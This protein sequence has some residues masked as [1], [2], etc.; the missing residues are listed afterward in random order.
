MMLMAVL[1]APPALDAQQRTDAPRTRRDSAAQALRGVLITAPRRAGT[2]TTAPR[3]VANMLTTGTKSEVIAISGT[4]T[5]VAE[6]VGRQLFAEVP[7]LFVYDMDGS[8]NQLN[9]SARGLDA[10]RS[11]EFSVRQNG[12]VTNSDVYGY[13]ASH[14]SAPMEAIERVELVRGTAALQYGSQFGGMLN[15][16]VKTP[17]TTRAATFDSRSS[18]GSFGLLSTWNSVGGKVGR[19]AY[20]AYASAR[21]SDGYRTNG[22]S[23]SDAEYASASLPLSSNLALRAD[24]ARSRYLYQQPGPLTD[25]MFAVDPRQSTR[26]RNWYSPDIIVPSVSLSWTPTS[27]TR[28]TLLVSGVFGSRSSVAIGGF[29]VQADTAVGGQFAVRQVDVD[30]YDSRTV[31]LRGMHDRT[32]FSR[33]STLSAGVILSDNDLWRRQRGAGSRGTDYSL[34]LQPNATFQRNLHYL[35]ENIAAFSELEVRVTPLWTIIPGARVERGTT[36]LRGSLAYYDPADTP[37]NVSHNFPLFGIRSSY[38][39]VSGGEWYGGGSQAYR[40]MILKDVLPETATERTDRTLKDA[41]GWTIET[42]FRRSF[43]GGFSY[44]V[45]GFAMRYANR[46]GLLTLTDSLGAAYT[47]KTNVGT[48]RTLGLEGRVGLPLGTTHGTAFRAFSA[49][50]VM[51]ARYVAGTV[52]SGRTNVS[53]RGNEV[54]SAPH[55]IVR[56]GLTAI[57]NRFSLT[58]QV[59]HV[60]RTFADARNT[61]TPS[62]NGATGIVPAYTLVDLHGSLTLPRRIALSGG[63]SNL[64]DLHYFTKRPQFYPGPGVWPSDG[65]S[66]FLSLGLYR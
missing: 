53:V 12:V 28:A 32:L 15:Y 51:D 58:T 45:G 42:G 41:R 59:S 40:P 5:N 38:R 7:G 4:T 33:P 31:E 8:G 44:D 39:F 23:T 30:R 49:A 6:K 56:G 11:W 16:V 61:A 21:R 34:T 46:F 60:S 25:I 27:T 24:I 62:A 65:R 66:V 48:S 18:G 3:L 14:Y 64:F 9:V 2:V 55:L 29:A 22:K 36:R 13:P 54:E 17:D 35:T 50:S 37:R 26:S 19:V 47:Y 20:Y 10:H 43:A 1:A 63:V 52:I 57:S